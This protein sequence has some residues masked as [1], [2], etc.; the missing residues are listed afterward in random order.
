[1]VVISFFFFGVEK[2]KYMLI[3]KRCGCLCG[4]IPLITYVHVFSSHFPF[5]D[6]VEN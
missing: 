6:L 4:V 2:E 3:I 5:S 1:M